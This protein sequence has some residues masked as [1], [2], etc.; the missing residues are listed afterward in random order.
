MPFSPDE[1]HA[2]VLLSMM[3][4]TA[5]PDLVDQTREFLLN[6]EED[7]T[8]TPK[9]PV[10]REA[11][12][13]LEWSRATARGDQAAA[14]GHV[15]QMASEENTNPFPFGRRWRLWR[16]LMQIRCVFPAM[17]PTTGLLRQGILRLG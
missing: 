17:P 10:E 7:P 9:T 11:A 8:R 16:R 1:Q 5:P 3:R 6:L 15:Q 12:L 4:E 13:L 14:D 2:A